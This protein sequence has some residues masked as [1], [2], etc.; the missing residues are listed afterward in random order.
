M[1]TT[2]EKQNH[3]LKTAVIIMSILL[4]GCFVYIFQFAND[5]K[6]LV[7]TVE[8][9]KTEQEIAMEKLQKLKESFDDAISKKTAL[10]DALI[11]EQAKVQ[12]L[13]ALLESSKGDATVLA[14]V[15]SKSAVLESSAKELIAKNESMFAAMNDPD[16]YRI[17]VDSVL[18]IKNEIDQSKKQLD[19][20]LKDLKTSVT[21]ASKINVVDLSAR[22]FH[23]HD[24]KR[25]V[26]TDEAKEAEQI[27]VTFTIPEN[28]LATAETK[29]FYVQIIDPNNNVIGLKKTVTIGDKILTYS[30]EEKIDYQNKTM[31]FTENI[32]AN[33]LSAGDYKVNVFLQNDLMTKT[34]FRLK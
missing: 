30:L 6:I 2:L 33:N 17:R 16:K 26:E 18:A 3:S 15:Q 4:V 28:S 13:M 24:V 1:K 5:T 10:S 23:V 29:Q 9:V 21:K 14:D 27:K 12:N 34:T 25:A 22:I 20:Q 31:E 32:Y 11:A 8:R 7:K 19:T